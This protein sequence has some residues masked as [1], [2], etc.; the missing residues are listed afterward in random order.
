MICPPQAPT[1][2]PPVRESHSFKVGDYVRIIND[3]QTFRKGHQSQVSKDIYLIVERKYNRYIL[4]N[5][6]TDKRLDRAYASWQLIKVQNMDKMIRKPKPL[7]KYK[8]DGK[9]RSKAEIDSDDT[10]SDEYEH[11]DESELDEHSEEEKAEII[12]QVDSPLKPKRNRK[13]PVDFGQQ[14]ETPYHI[15]KQQEKKAKQQ[16]KK[17]QNDKSSKYKPLPRKSTKDKDGDNVYVYEKEEKKTGEDLAGQW[18]AKNKEETKWYQLIRIDGKL[19]FEGVYELEDDDVIL[20]A[21]NDNTK[22]KSRR[23]MSHRKKRK[24]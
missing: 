5:R 23:K 10:D 9:K 3:K 21:E 11:N 1:H 17:Q 15:R 19:W 13:K 24:K 7:P 16:S 6:K 2:K 4:H 12:E 20:P 22:S 18:V 14:Q 8:R